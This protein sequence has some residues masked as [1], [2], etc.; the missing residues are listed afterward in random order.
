MLELEVS[1]WRPSISDRPLAQCEML[2][3]VEQI[4]ID[5]EAIGKLEGVG[6]VP[7]TYA[8]ALILSQDCDLEFDQRARRSLASA[9][10]QPASGPEREAWDT[11][12]R[13]SK[14]KLMNGVLLCAAEDEATVKAAAD[15]SGQPWRF[16]R[17]NQHERFHFLRACD[18]ANDLENAG[19]PS[20]V[21]DFKRFFT[22]PS[23][24]LAARSL[25]AE[26]VAG[27]ARRRA[28]L[29]SPFLEEVSARFYTYQSR[30]AVPDEGRPD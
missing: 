4:A 20:L 2:C 29:A 25:L 13:K 15:Q 6:F 3:E 28:V 22:I 11:S 14:S 26:G 7:T 27:R 9:G 12:D 5:L 8:F 30:V 19:F 21:L 23:E 16:A 24:E 1:Y 18:P 10:M 17:S